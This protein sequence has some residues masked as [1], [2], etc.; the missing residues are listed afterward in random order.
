MH[1]HEDAGI[2]SNVA[3][4]QGDV[5]VSVNIV[6]IS[7]HPP[8]SRLSRK[9]RFGDAMYQAFFL[10]AVGY[11]LRDSDERQCVLGREAF[12]LGTAGAGAIFTEDLADDTSRSESS[13]TGEVDSSFR[14]TY[15]LQHATLARAEGGNMAWPA[16]VRRNRLRI[17]GY[18]NCPGPILRAHT[19][20]DSEPFVGIDGHGKRR[21]E[22]LGVR[23]TLRGQLELIRPLGGMS[24]A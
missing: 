17:H 14:M 24:E 15:A 7:D 19:R 18:L 3:E 2:G 5:L 9:P 23:F 8:H 6:S 20:C 13:Q 10:E 22:F 21:P 1:S 16:K 12:Q 4:D 11:E